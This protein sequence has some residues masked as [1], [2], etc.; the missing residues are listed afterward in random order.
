MMTLVDLSC[1]RPHFGWSAMDANDTDEELHGDLRVALLR[2]EHVYELAVLIH[3]SV[4]VP[5]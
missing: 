3:R 1:F 4:D 2:H 5:P